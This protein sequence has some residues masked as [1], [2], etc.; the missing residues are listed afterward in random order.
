M[1]NE[2]ALWR[3]HVADV[4]LEDPADVVFAHH[5]SCCIVW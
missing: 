3:R 1:D 2:A 5:L 4:E